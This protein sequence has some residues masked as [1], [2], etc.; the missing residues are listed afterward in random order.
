MSGGDR[1]TLDTEVFGWMDGVTNFFTFC[2]CCLCLISLKYL[3]TFVA[4]MNSPLLGLPSSLRESCSF[5][6][7]VHIGLSMLHWATSQDSVR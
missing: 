2:F 1:G 3:N 5:G 6:V 7:A 4:R